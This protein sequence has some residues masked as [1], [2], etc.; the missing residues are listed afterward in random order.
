[1]PPFDPNIDAAF[2]EYAEL[3]LRCHHL[4][5]EGKGDTPE[6]L[7]AEDRMTE[8]WE[9]LDEV[10]RQSL[11]GMGSDLNW[12]RRKGEPPPNGRKKPEEVTP[13]ERQALEEATDSKDWH[14]IL[15][16]L[17]LCAPGLPLVTLAQLRGGAY[18]AIR[19]PGYA[20]V[21]HERAAE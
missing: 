7:E 19:F 21:F 6:I 16:F 18:D 11:S 9:R 2:R 20:R 8:L 5:L 15:H 13:A 12:V 14:G 1:M 4:L 3:E 10:Q 17:R